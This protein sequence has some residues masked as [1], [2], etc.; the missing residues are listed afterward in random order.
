MSHYL[1]LKSSDLCSDMIFHQIYKVHYAVSFFFS[2]ICLLNSLSFLFMGL[3]HSITCIFMQIL[4]HKEQA[5]PVL[6]HK[7]LAS[8]CVRIF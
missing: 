1:H 2:T 7:I 8:N 3:F 6:D 5:T 4:V